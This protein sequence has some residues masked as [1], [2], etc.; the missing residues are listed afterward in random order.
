M[1]IGISLFPARGSVNAVDD[2][3]ARARGAARAGFQSA[4][5]NQAFD[6]DAIA[7]AGIV[8]REAPELAV[9]TAAVPIFGRHP[10]TVAAQAQTT[11]AATRGRYSLGV[12]M[13]ARFVVEGAYGIP[14]ERP[15]ALLREFLTALRSLFNDDTPAF[16]GELLSSI[17]P[18]PTSLAGASPAVPILVAAMGPQALRVTGELADGILPYLAGPRALDDHIVPAIV[19]A[20]ERAGRPAP[21]VVALVPAVVCSDIDAARTVAQEH[22]GFHNTIPSYQRVIALSGASRTV[23]LLEAGDEETVAA[24]IHRYF[25]AGAT[26]VVVTHT[27]LLGDAARART[28]KLLGELANI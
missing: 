10:I 16:R 15:I 6:Y 23:D 28:W 8:G 11:Q 5:F 9:G 7:L 2:V 27:D 4:W 22:I 12:G 14:H 25:E 18:M 26:E 1:K 19:S 13:G 20:A 17:R 24:G 21:R 3:V